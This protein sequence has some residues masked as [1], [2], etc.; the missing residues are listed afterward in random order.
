MRVIDCARVCFMMSVTTTVALAQPK[1]ENVPKGPTMSDTIAFSTVVR[2]PTSSK[3]P[4]ES[5]F[6]CEHGMEYVPLPAFPAGNYTAYVVK[7]KAITAE[8]TAWP[9]AVAE[10]HKLLPN[11]STQIAYLNGNQSASLA[12]VFGGST[13]REHIAIDFMK[14]RSEDIEHSP[15]KIVYGRI[16]AGMRLEIDVD[17]KDASIGGSL[18]ALAASAKAGRTVGTIKVDVIGIDAKDVTMSMPFTTD[19]SEGS[20]QKI[21]EALAIVKS[22]LNDSSTTV[23]PQYIARIRCADGIKTT[24]KSGGRF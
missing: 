23:V 2:P 5:P 13:R 14:Y 19:L 9:S 10:V 8:I 3:P 21:I 16:G 15:G 24:E 12:G 1:I 6:M 18:F 22:R 11:I 17:T 7:D 20:I 4:L